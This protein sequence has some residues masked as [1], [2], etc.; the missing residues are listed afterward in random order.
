MADSTALAISGAVAR[1]SATRAFI[2]RLK[3]DI[4]T[5]SRR[6]SS[7]RTARCTTATARLV[8]AVVSASRRRFKMAGTDRPCNSRSPMLSP[9]IRTNLPRTMALSFDE[10]SSS[11][12]ARRSCSAAARASSSARTQCSSIRARRIRKMF[13]IARAARSCCSELS[14]CGS[15]H[16][17][18]E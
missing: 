1:Y 3:V 17:S 9:A 16:S 13:W 15:S 7:I 12:R 11:S 5:I 14:Q 10:A 2:N 18:A 6:A 8:L 4:R